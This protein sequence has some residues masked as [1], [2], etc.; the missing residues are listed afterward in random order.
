MGRYLKNAFRKEETRFENFIKIRENLRRFS[1]VSVGRTETKEL[2]GV[3][4][5]S[6]QRRNLS[7]PKWG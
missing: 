2:Q 6:T 1:V 5:N 7:S 3:T 4:F